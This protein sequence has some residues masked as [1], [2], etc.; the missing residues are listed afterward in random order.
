MPFIARWPGHIKPG[1]SDALV[2]SMDFLASFAA[3]AG[4]DVPA[5]A[6]PDSF[7]VLPALLGQSK[8]GREHLLEHSGVVAIRKGPWK[9]I[10]PRAQ[11][12]NA[13]RQNGGPLELFNLAQ[14]PGETKNVAA[15]NPEIVRELSAMLEKQRT[16]GR[17]RP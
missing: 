13:R 4:R 2:G 1:T 11:T 10:P 6:A 14:D 16:S 7:N 12:P 17:T 15:E 9:L 3:L 5:D 8:K